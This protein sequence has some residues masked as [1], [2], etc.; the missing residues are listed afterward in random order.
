MPKCLPILVLISSV[1][2]SACASQKVANSE[3]LQSKALADAAAIDISPEEMISRASQ[4]L[5]NA[6]QDLR[7]YSP[8]HMQK[9]QEQ[10]ETARKLQQSGKEENKTGALAA[11]ILAEKLVKQAEENREQVKQQLAPALSHR[12]I[13]MELGAADLLPGDFN[14]AMEDLQDLIILVESGQLDAVTKKQPSLLEAFAQ[15]E[16]DTL[17]V[18]WLNRAKAKLEQAEDTDADKFAPK[19]FEQAELAIERADSYT[20]SNY[21][22]REGV[23]AKADEAFVLASKALNVALEVQKVYEKKISELE[24]YMLDV[25]SWL[26]IINQ[27]LKVPDLPAL[28]FNEQSRTLAAKVFEQSKQT[29]VNVQNSVQ[30][31]TAK[32]IEPEVQALP[33]E[34]ILIVNPLNEVSDPETAKDSEDETQMSLEDSAFSDESGNM[35]AAENEPAESQTVQ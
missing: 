3:A 9:A 24:N 1:L 35:P 7:F 11:A 18:K 23:K 25:Q 6:D 14:S 2:I 33:E 19:S 12:A 27:G 17:K 15:L 29:A 4:R 13:L 10:L 22:D 28:R 8:L 32:E 21:R 26:D 5:N 31:D 16:A 20:D 30:A 34:A